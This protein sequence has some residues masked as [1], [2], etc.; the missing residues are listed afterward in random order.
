[1][2][3]STQ[4]PLADNKFN[5]RF[6]DWAATMNETTALLRYGGRNDGSLDSGYISAFLFAHAIRAP[7]RMIRPVLV[8]LV[9][10]L[11]AP[12]Y[13]AAAEITLQ[14][15][16]ITITGT[17]EQDDWAKFINIA[18]PL[19]KDP[20]IVLNSRGGWTGAAENIGHFIRGRKLTTLVRNGNECSS[21]CT[22]IWISG[23]P[24]LLELEAKLGFH[25]T[26]FPE[27]RRK[28]NEDGNLK[29][30]EYLHKMGAPDKL[31]AFQPRAAPWE[32]DYINYNTA[33]AW[34]LIPRT[35]WDL[36]EALAK[37]TAAPPAQPDPV[38]PPAQPP[39]APPVQPPSWL[40]P[41]HR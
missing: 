36:M 28:R 32:L 18:F 24:H 7:N 19:V 39:A 14:K 25:S 15:D 13:A 8:L 6:G 26:S 16:E 20:I 30:G 21:A 9:A 41:G 12:A 31:V 22:L 37:P 38:L 2:L 35:A 4:P 40:F 5:E 11:M 29:F 33:K 23:S 27:D 10:A 17:I 34:G 3:D 1:V